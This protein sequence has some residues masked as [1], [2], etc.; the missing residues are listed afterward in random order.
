MGYTVAVQYVGQRLP[1][2]ASASNELRAPSRPL[3]A[4]ELR[5]TES[6][7]VRT[8]KGWPRI[9]ISLLGVLVRGRSGMVVM[10]GLL[11]AGSDNPLEA[12]VVPVGIPAS[13]MSN[14][15]GVRNG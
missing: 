8:D 5:C 4:R 11:A 13:E 2:Y 15:I 9:G 3:Q 14:E 7:G 1:E 12:L 6:W 10:G